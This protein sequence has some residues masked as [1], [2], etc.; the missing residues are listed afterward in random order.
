[1]RKDFRKGCATLAQGYRAILP[2]LRKAAQ[3]PQGFL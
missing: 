2:A 3:G 1:L